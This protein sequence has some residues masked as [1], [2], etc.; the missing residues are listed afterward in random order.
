[1]DYDI[2]D[3]ETLSTL[4]MAELEAIEEFGNDYL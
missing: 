1:M 2:S 3:L 4:D